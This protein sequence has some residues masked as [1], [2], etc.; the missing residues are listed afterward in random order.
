MMFSEVFKAL[1]WGR[2]IQ[3]AA[4]GKMLQV[5]LK[6]HVKH[7]QS[8]QKIDKLKF[9]NYCALKNTIKKVKRQGFPWWPS[10]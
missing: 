5:V 4:W 1:A 6:Y 7:K 2:L 10:S 8:K 9:K 3:P